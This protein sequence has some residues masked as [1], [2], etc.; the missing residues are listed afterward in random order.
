MKP[1]GLSA[2]LTVWLLA[3]LAWAQA[4]KVPTQTLKAITQDGRMV[5]L[6][7]N[8]TWKYADAAGSTTIGSSRPP[9][10]TMLLAG[11]QVPYGIWIDQ[12][13]WRFTDPKQNMAAELEL[14][15]VSNQAGA[16]VVAEPRQIPPDS[17][18]QI[19]INNARR[20]A[21]DA[22]ITREERKVVNGV[23]VLLLQSEGTGP[24]GPFVYYG[25]YYAGPRGAV[26]VV[27]YT[28]AGTFE[29]YRADF[30]AFLDGFV[31]LE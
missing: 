8:G 17:W 22:R 30:T 31:V 3:G 13:R 18:K 24:L 21:S 27:T 6:Q 19:V 2:V 14:T 29:Q 20:E 23:P 12:A 1:A 5:V 26:Q 10:A 9:G 7:A 16:L 28:F 4:G 25:Y 11:R 15:H